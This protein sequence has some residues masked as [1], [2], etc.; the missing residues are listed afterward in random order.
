MRDR[1]GPARRFYTTPD[2]V[3]DMEAIRQQLGVE[4]LT[5]FG[6]S[7]GTELA[8]AYARAYPQHVQRLVLDSVVDYDDRDPFATV[9]FRAMG[10]SLKSLCPGGCRRHLQ[11]RRRSRQA[12]RQLR[13]TPLQAFAYNAQGRWTRVKITP[14]ALFDLMLLTDYLPALRAAIPAGV[15]P[16]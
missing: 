10:P 16:H 6:V 9:L 13:A 11:T 4:K 3:L 7:Y 14:T 15:Q 2:S 1:I 5:L 8:V 12:R